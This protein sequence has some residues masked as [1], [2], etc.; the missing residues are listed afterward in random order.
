M[1]EKILN[2]IAELEKIQA[3]I[4]TQAQTQ[5]AQ[6]ALVLGELRNLLNDNNSS[7]NLNSKIGEPILP[8]PPSN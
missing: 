1:E 8:Q 2:R 7:D 6:L 4:T 3:E 5:L